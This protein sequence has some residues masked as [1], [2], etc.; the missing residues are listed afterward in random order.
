MSSVSHFYSGFIIL[1]RAVLKLLNMKIIFLNIF[2]LLRVSFTGII[3]LPYHFCYFINDIISDV[4]SHFKILLLTDDA[5]I[6]KD[7]S[8]LKDA[9][10][11]QIV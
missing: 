9:L 3:Y 8:C 7:I 2:L 10:K 6:C 5:K 11:L 1:F 4:I